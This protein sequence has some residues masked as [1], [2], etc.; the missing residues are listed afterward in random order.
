MEKKRARKNE[1]KK[2]QK[3]NRS[4]VRGN[5]K[6]AKTGPSSPGICAQNN[7]PFSRAF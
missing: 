7:L 2:W 6:R 4:K 5:K 3:G 1:V